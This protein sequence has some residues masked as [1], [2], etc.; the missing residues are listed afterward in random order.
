M[1][2]IPLKY[3]GLLGLTSLLCGLFQSCA[4]SWENPPEVPDDKSEILLHTELM[5]GIVVNGLLTKL[6][7]FSKVGTGDYLLTDSLPQVVSGTSRL[8]LSLADLETNDYRFLFIA[9]PEANPEITVRRKDNYALLPDATWQDITIGA[10]VE[11]LSIDNYYGIKD[12]TGSEILE[13]KEITADLTRLV[14]QMVFCFYKVGPG[15]VKDPVAVDDPNVASVMDRVSSIDVTYEGVPRLV[16]FGAGN[17]PVA[18][19]GS[20]STINHIVRFSLMDDGQK[21]NLPQEEISVEVADS[22]PGGAI[23][24]GACLLPSQQSVRVSMVF[25][26][27]DTTP[28]CENFEKGHMHSTACY[29][30]NTLSLHL[31]QSNSSQG[32]SVLRDCFTINN[33]GLPCNRVIDI[34]HT[35]GFDVDT[36]WN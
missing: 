19:A 34:Q 15:G 13:K 21:V 25:H 7:V 23:L 1:K 3:V 22:I 17:E 9:T 31:P 18:L 33:S 24:K 27:Y 11:N 16:T 14:G 32:L 10:T 20:E 6:Y 12:M 36:K 8:K 5:N 4:T 28:I 35:S 29:T 26:Y 2:L 30:P